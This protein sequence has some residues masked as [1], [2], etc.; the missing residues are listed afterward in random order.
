MVPR[1]WRWSSRRLKVLRW[2][3]EAGL[4]FLGVLV[5]YPCDG[6]VISV[7]GSSHLFFFDEFAR[8]LRILFCLID[9]D[10][11]DSAGIETSPRLL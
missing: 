10:D 9:D 2:T 1:A 7:F 11:D 4:G 5:V 8:C 6:V 3:W